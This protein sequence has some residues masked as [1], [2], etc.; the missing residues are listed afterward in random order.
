MERILKDRLAIFLLFLLALCLSSCGGGGGSNNEP[1]S[2]DTELIASEVIE[3]QEAGRQIYT[4]YLS[5]EDPEALQKTVDSLKTQSNIEDAAVGEDGVSIWIKYDTGVEGIILTQSFKTL[6]N[7]SSLRAKPQITNKRNRFSTGSDREKAIILLPIDSEPLYQDTSAESIESALQQSDY[8]VEIYRDEAVT[9]DLMKKLSEYQVIYISTHGGIGFMGTGL[10]GNIQIMT[11]EIA[12]NS[13]IARFWN[14]LKAG[15]TSGLTLFTPCNSDKTYFGL[16]SNF[17]DDYTYPNS[18]IY[19]N[20]CS[21]LKNDSLADA[22]LNNG[23]SVYIGWDNISFLALGNLHNPEFFEELSKSGSTF[24]QAYN[25]TI[26]QYYPCT[27][28]E[29]DNDNGQYHV[30]LLNDQDLGDPD[31]LTIDY[32][33]N[34][35]YKGNAEFVLNPILLSNNPPTATITTP[36]D[37]S[38]FTEGDEI[39]FIGT[40]IDPENGNL[41]GSYLVWTSDKD[42]EIGAGESFT[43][44]TLS[45]NTHTVTLTVTDYSNN[46]DTDSITIA[47]YSQSLVQNPWPMFGYNPQHTGQSTYTGTQTN[48]V[49][50][51]FTS[52][53]YPD[54]P[55]ISSNGTIY[56]GGRDKFYALNPNGTLKW[57]FSTNNNG[58]FNHCPAIGP[59]GTIYISEGNV[60]KFYAL[61]PEDGSIKWCF[62]EEGGANWSFLDPTIHDG[63]IYVIS[64][65]VYSK[66]Y[67][68]NPNGT[69]NWHLSFGGSGSNVSIGSSPAVDADGTIYIGSSKKI[70]YALNPDGSVKWSYETGGQLCSLPPAIGS[71]G[72]IY[73][74][75]TDSNLYAFNASGTLKWKCFVRGEGSTSIE[76]SPSISS[77]G[78][79]YVGT[80]D[81]YIYA[82]NP[83]GTIKWEKKIGDRI[84]SSP[85]IGADETIY[86]GIDDVW[87]D[88]TFYAL[89]PNGSITWSS[90]EPGSIDQSPAIGPDGTV[91]ISSWCLYAFGE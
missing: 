72:T 26:A 58:N 31:D 22:F 51:K 18:L 88:Y 43:I 60:G 10:G 7:S 38:I 85:A 74:G 3:T 80:V 17:F 48:N 54:S 78:T 27:V 29:D 90:D 49:K 35:K 4:D 81:G 57:S 12:D 68:L 69:K 73:I 28:Y 79:I 56:I 91:Y 32:T 30:S 46:I 47:I 40:G 9:V 11:G 5:Q 53:Q 75:S 55:V 61:N 65:F 59:D 52:V 89:D 66:L 71:D 63:T 16:N 42:G 62:D 33:L 83:D 82:I 39:T 86:F 19:I 1:S 70:F 23:A 8:S 37:G 24:Q 77:N 84:Y 64:I 6:D 87:E 15:A 41:T 20:T 44:G 25:D 76:S 50:W 34:L 36:T 13:A 67:A 14:L 21:S 2:S 45:A